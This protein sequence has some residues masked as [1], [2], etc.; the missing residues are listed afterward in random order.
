MDK[1][2]PD[3]PEDRKTLLLATLM[4]PEMLFWL[5][6]VLFGA[7][8]AGWFLIGVG[9]LLALIPFLVLAGYWIFKKRKSG[10]NELY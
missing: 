2:I 4:N 8:A 5:G 3:S 10:K 1:I 7:A 6:I 9:V